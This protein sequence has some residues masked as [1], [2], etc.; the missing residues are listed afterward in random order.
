MVEVPNLRGGVGEEEGL[1]V[2][3]SDLVGL[4]VSLFARQKVWRVL[5]RVW[6]SSG[7]SA[8]RQR[9]SANSSRLR[10]EWRISAPMEGWRV[11]R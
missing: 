2:T 3:T 11:V 5:R 10:R 8:M 6:S 9:S 1:K 4:T 7:D